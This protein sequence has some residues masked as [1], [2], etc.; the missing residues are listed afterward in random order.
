MLIGALRRK[1]FQTNI[2]ISFDL[3]AIAA[4]KIRAKR[5]N[6]VVSNS[7]CMVSDFVCR[8]LRLR[9]MI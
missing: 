8:L 4:F 1:P 9:T 2:G 3:D 6:F 7:D 5:V